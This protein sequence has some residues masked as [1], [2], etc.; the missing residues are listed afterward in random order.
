MYM[1]QS[2]ELEDVQIEG[3]EESYEQARSDS[4]SGISTVQ[5]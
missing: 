4:Q 3:E 2:F 1:S 5:G